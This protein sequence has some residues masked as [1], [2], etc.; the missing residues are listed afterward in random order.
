MR[1]ISAAAWMSFRKIV[2][3]PNMRNPAK[4]VNPI[5][6]RLIQTGLL[7]PFDNRNSKASVAS[8]SSFELL[9]PFQFSKVPTF[10][11]VYITLYQ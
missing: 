3:G 6:G 10:D 9:G 4:A 7:P 2:I 1:V 5:L 11:C 8:H